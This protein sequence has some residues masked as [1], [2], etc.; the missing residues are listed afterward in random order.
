MALP[1]DAA[2]AREEAG[3]E[4]L[5]QA[6]DQANVE[7]E[8][9]SKHTLPR[10]VIAKF[11]READDRAV[12]AAGGKGIEAMRARHEQ[13]PRSG[14]WRRLPTAAPAISAE[15][16]AAA[17][18]KAKLE[19]LRPR[20]V[21]RVGWMWKE[22][23]V[24]KSWKRRLFVLYESEIEYYAR[25]TDEKPKGVISLQNCTVSPV[26]NRAGVTKP[27]MELVYGPKQRRWHFMAEILPENRRWFAAIR[28]R[29]FAQ[30]YADSCARAGTE[31]D[32]R[33]VDFLG[34]IPAEDR[35]AREA[36]SGLQVQKRHSAGGEL[37]EW[38]PSR[39]LTL[40]GRALPLDAVSVLSQVLSDCTVCPNGGVSRLDLSRSSLGPVEI[41]VVA[42]ALARSDYNRELLP[43][44]RGA[45]SK[46][47]DVSTTRLASQG[48]GA[49]FRPSADLHGL[50]R[51]DLSGNELVSAGPRQ[52][53]DAGEEPGVKALA[54]ALA[55]NVSMRELMLERCGIHD[56]ALGALLAGLAGTACPLELLSLGGNRITCEGAQAL[57]AAVGVA[58]PG[59]GTLLLHDNRVADEGADALAVSL[60]GSEGPLRHLSLA[61]NPV[62]ADG[63][64]AIAGALR[65]NRCALVSLDLAGNEAFAGRDEERQF[66]DACREHRSLEE[67][68][69]GRHHLTLTTLQALR[70]ASA[71][72]RANE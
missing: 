53:A 23:G 62:G 25:A 16:Q 39:P 15:E 72:R 30:A 52:G 51:L 69:F 4:Q 2:L 11:E 35:S 56:D 31:P 38:A 43:A 33:I 47:S 59:L 41:E 66:A 18:V 6:E 1:G 60:L 14:V 7:L 34:F 28:N 27:C 37:E 24:V 26:E 21:F 61:G 29:V 67:A 50:A 13:S 55:A 12:A 70:V 54:A 3:L 32:E 46:E 19:R 64:A 57:A 58:T 20:K 40:S 68:R 71:S 9:L 36:L 17:D 22:G 44:A 45:G 10:A 49:H 5:R 65:A 63:L 48:T 42:A 8:Y